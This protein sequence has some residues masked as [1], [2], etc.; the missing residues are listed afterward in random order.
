[1]HPDYQGQGF[2]KELLNW[3][4]KEA[5]RLDVCTSLVSSHRGNRFYRKMGYT[6]EVGMCTEGEGNLLAGI[7]SGWILFWEE[8]DATK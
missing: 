3:G 4:I 2:A 7:G 5:K 1:M 6:R 8:G